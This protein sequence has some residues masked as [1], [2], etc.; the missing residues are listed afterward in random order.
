MPG[1]SVRSRGNLLTVA[2]LP[3]VLPPNGVRHQPQIPYS[4]G[5]LKARPRGFEPLT[6]GSVA[7]NLALAGQISPPK[8]PSNRQEFDVAAVSRDRQVR[9]C[10]LTR[11]RH[12]SGN[13]RDAEADDCVSSRLLRK[14]AAR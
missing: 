12:V 11:F 5:I 3:P 10:P 7:P 8:S 4:T 6:F 9:S 14:V 2:P 1:A 13:T